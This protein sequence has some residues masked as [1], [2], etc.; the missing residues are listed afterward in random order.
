MSDSDHNSH[1][2]GKSTELNNNVTATFS[3]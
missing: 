1:H 3:A 2:R